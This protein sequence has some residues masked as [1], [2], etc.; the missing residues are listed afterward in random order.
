MFFNI[1]ILVDR[2]DT[3][4]NETFLKHHIQRFCKNLNIRVSHKYWQSPCSFFILKDI[5]ILTSPRE[6]MID[7]A[8]MEPYL[9][10]KI[11]VDMHKILAYSN[12]T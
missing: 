8:L 2:D 4:L 7:F 5:L 12:L 1:T 11:M 3:K 10:I 6:N 9:E